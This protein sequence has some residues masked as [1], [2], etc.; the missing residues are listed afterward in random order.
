VLAPAGTP[1]PVVEKLNNALVVAPRK[2]DVIAKLKQQG[3]VAVA[4]GPDA[5][6]RR[7]QEDIAVYDR[8]IPSIGIQP[9]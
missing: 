7:I 2:P 3:M 6:A 5:L 8:L 4:E 1:K 9:E